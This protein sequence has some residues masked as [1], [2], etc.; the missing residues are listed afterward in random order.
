MGG[1]VEYEANTFDIC[2]MSAVAYSGSKHGFIAPHEA[3][4]ARLAAG[5]KIAAPLQHSATRPGCNS[6]TPARQ[7]Y[8]RNSNPP[9]VRTDGKEFLSFCVS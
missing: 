7:E 8:H 2:P 6:L 1:R 3:V 4:P 9:A 5:E